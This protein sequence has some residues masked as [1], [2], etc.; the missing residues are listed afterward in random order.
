MKR[1]EEVYGGLGKCKC[2]DVEFI[3]CHAPEGDDD[4]PQRYIKGE[5]SKMEPPIQ[6]F[7]V[8]V[9]RI[10][11]LPNIDGFYELE[12]AICR[13]ENG[14]VI[15]ERLASVVVDGVSALYNVDERRVVVPCEAYGNSDT[16]TGPNSNKV[17]VTSWLWVYPIQ[18]SP[19][20]LK[21]VNLT[22]EV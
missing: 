19:L 6:H 9:I 15:I 3:L 10:G 12:Q 2:G 11:E 22:K 17:Y 4:L 16:L 1:I 20:S 14:K 18:Q 7:C 13:Y 5:M 8:P 21:D